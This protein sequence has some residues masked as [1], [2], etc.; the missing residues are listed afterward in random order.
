MLYSMFLLKQLVNSYNN[1]ILGGSDN[2]CML[3]CPLGG[4]TTIVCYWYTQVAPLVRLVSSLAFSDSPFSQ[5]LDN[6]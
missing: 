1:I 4:I 2:L 6:G 3:Y 5:R